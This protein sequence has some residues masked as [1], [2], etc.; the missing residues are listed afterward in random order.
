[1]KIQ[2]PDL[3]SNNEIQNR[4]HDDGLS[5]AEFEDNLMLSTL[6]N[7]YMYLQSSKILYKNEQLK[8]Q[9]KGK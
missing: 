4:H 3:F 6:P 9:R 5:W 8:E 2:Q 7:Y 1:M